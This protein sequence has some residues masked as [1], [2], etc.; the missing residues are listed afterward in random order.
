M[1]LVDA[2]ILMYAAGA[3][4]PSKGPSISFLE[5]VATG[6]I[7]AAIDAETLQE[8]LH[9]YRA[10]HRWDDGKA[11]FDLARRIFVRVIPIDAEVLDRARQLLDTYPRLMARDALHAAIVDI[12]ALSAIC[13]FD[14]DFDQ[15]SEIQRLEPPIRIGHP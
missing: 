9:R 15:I 4:H 14:R 2:N 7:D 10:L 13:S 12:N 5:M 6:E 11:V 1:I 3:D 8:I